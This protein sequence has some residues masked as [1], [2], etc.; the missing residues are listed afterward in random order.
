MPFC[1]TAAVDDWCWKLHPTRDNSSRLALM[2]ATLTTS[3]RSTSPRVTPFPGQ[4]ARW[5]RR[6]LDTAGTPLHRRGRCR[7][8]LPNTPREET[9]W[10]R[11]FIR[12]GWRKWEVTGISWCLRHGTLFSR[13]RTLLLASTMAFTNKK[14]TCKTLTSLS[15]SNLFTYGQRHYISHDSVQNQSNVKQWLKER[16]S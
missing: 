2:V 15:L 9:L 14:T 16:G 3:R 11:A 12:A 6:R 10:P 5:W 8:H 4:M 7:T 13:S 1:F